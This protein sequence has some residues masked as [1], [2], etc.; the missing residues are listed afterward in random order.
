MSLLRHVDFNKDIDR[1]FLWDIVNKQTFNV[2]KNTKKKHV[3]QTS[4]NRYWD[5]LVIHISYNSTNNVK[6]LFG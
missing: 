6:L 5:L 2:T 1:L 4:G 3:L